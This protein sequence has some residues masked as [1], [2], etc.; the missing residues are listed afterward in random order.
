MNFLKNKKRILLLLLFVITLSPL[1]LK[2]S[3]NSEN[4]GGRIE[5]YESNLLRLNSVDLLL[6]YIDSLY[7]AT[8]EG[9]FDTTEYVNLADKITENR[10]YFGLSTYNFS[11]NWIAYLGGKM[12]W[13]HF[14]AIVN[15]DDILKHAEGLC[16]QQTIVFMELMK[17]KGINVRSVGLGKK[18]GP[19]HFV[20]EVEYGKGWHLYDVTLEPA[21]AIP[22][23]KNQSADFYLRNI[24][25]FY[26]A[27]DGRVPKEIFDKYVKNV[28]YGKTN[29]FPAQNMLLF[30]RITLYLTY[31]LPFLFLFL[32]L[33]DV[34]KK[35]QPEKEN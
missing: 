21:L 4:Q 26:K 22:K 19:G 20:C 9:I 3:V 7:A 16:S 31:F 13:S 18:E 2:V 5:F 32:L 29:Y 14:I 30:H 35:I 25:T 33:M 12:L 6:G 27:Y 34:Y 17:R 24:D 1:L 28:E 8:N 11:E 23:L 10:F 15:P